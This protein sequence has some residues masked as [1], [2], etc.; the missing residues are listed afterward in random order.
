MQVNN[1]ITSITV[2]GISNLM[3]YTNIV[4]K[5]SIYRTGVVL[6]TKIFIPIQ[7]GMEYN[8]PKNT[9]P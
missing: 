6:K 1:G 3:A 9:I 4:R 2:H 8:T 7:R 5:G